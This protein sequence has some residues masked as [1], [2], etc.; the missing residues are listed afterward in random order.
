MMRPAIALQ[1]ADANE[2]FYFIADYHA[3][4]TIV[5]PETLRTNSRRIALDFLACGL[6]VERGGTLFRQSDAP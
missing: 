3:L 6:D 2:T 4:T 5:N 1:E